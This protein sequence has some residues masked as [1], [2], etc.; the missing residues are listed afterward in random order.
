MI[1]LSK[2]KEIIEAWSISMKP[3]EQ[4]KKQAIIRYAV[5]KSCEHNKP[6]TTFG[7]V[8]N[9][10]NCPLSKKV[11]SVRKGACD[12]GRWNKIDGL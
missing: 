8:C 9:L 3:N 1:S 2:L 6:T 12:D 5:C 11:F 7:E 4:Q 10:C